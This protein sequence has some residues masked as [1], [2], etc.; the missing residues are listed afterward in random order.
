LLAR[1]IAH[2]ALVDGVLR[3]TPLPARPNPV[4][5]LRALWTTGYV[6]SSTDASGVTI[7]FPPL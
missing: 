6:L 2:A 1:S 4:N 7:G 3:A 5:P